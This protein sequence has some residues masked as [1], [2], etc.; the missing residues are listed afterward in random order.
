[1]IVE[2]VH[3]EIFLCE[4]GE[5]W[6]FKGLFMISHFNICIILNRISDRNLHN[7]N[8]NR[9]GDEIVIEKGS[10]KC[11]KYKKWKGKYFSSVINGSSSP[12]YIFLWNVL[13]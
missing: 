9:Q 4:F 5:K 12:N 8:E 11:K 3:A 7:Q 13:L 10:I 1:M 2:I 6:R